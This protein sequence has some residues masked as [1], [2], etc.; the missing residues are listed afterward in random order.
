MSYI[1]AFI[2][3]QSH[4]P[5]LSALKKSRSCPTRWQQPVNN[6]HGEYFTM[7]THFRACRIFLFTP[8]ELKFRSTLNVPRIYSGKVSSQWEAYVITRSTAREF[9][10]TRNNR[11]GGSSRDNVMFRKFTCRGHLNAQWQSL[12]NILVCFPKGRK[13]SARLRQLKKQTRTRNWQFWVT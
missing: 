5:V 11:E 12:S 3:L 2:W 7:L 10:R 4:S 6:V 1:D 13:N 8:Y 9:P